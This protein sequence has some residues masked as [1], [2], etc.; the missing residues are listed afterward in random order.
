MDT[1]LNP[2]AILET[3]RDLYT[4]SRYRAEEE[5]GLASQ[6]RDV[7]FPDDQEI[8]SRM[9]WLIGRAEQAWGYSVGLVFHHA[10]ITSQKDQCDALRHLFMGCAGHGVSL[11]DEWDDHIDRAEQVLGSLIPV[12]FDRS[13]F[14]YEDSAVWGEIAAENLE[15]SLRD[16]AEENAA[17]NFS[18]PNIIVRGARMGTGETIRGKATCLGPVADRKGGIRYLCAM[19][20]GDRAGQLITASQDEIEEITDPMNEA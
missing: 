6:Y 9:W 3:G 2:D 12:H 10:G 4:E 20:E 1:L 19:E 18:D 15:K 11:A 17:D 7:E 5:I 14:D 16:E 8:L 13:P